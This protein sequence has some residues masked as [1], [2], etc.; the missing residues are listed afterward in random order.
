MNNQAHNMHL[1]RGKN[2]Y[3]GEWLEGYFRRFPDYNPNYNNG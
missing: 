1:A 2:K 3:T